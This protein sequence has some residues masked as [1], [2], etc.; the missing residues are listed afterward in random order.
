MMTPTW[1]S[2][3][4]TV[5]LW[6]ADCRPIIRTMVRRGERTVDCCITDPPYGISL[7]SHGQRF[8]RD[9]IEIV[10][11]ES[12]ALANEIFDWCEFWRIPLCAFM[13]PYRQ[14]GIRWRN[15]LAWDKSG[16]VGIC[17]DR[18]TCWKR[19]FELIGVTGN[20]PLNGGRDDGVIRYPVNQTCF[21]NHP[22]EKPV[23]L[24]A[25]LVGKLTQ[26][27]DIIADP[28]MGSGTT[29]V[30]AVRLGR[31]FWGVEL[32]PEYFAIAKRRIQEELASRD[33]LEPHRPREQQA[34]MFG[35]T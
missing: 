6:N 34:E 24:L 28:V 21:A 23:G 11:D 14:W 19:S 17:G 8:V 29:G 15:I 16:A 3:C 22:C 13:S 31:S 5:K 25:Y 12:T 27:G 26:T 7:A 1:T 20:G 9:D 32:K 30:A 18:E 10:G 2:E 35:E 33:F 4:G